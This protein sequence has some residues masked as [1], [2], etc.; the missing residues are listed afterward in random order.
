MGAVVC[1]FGRRLRL[2][3]TSSQR[4]SR[5]FVFSPPSDLKLRTQKL[6]QNLHEFSSN[7]CSTLREFRTF[8]GNFQQNARIIMSNYAGILRRSDHA[9]IFFLYQ[10]RYKSRWNDF[11]SP[12]SHKLLSLKCFQIRLWKAPSVKGAVRYGRPQLCQNKKHHFRLRSAGS[13]RIFWIKLI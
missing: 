6:P 11:S 13:K 8:I 5:L 2:Q 10:A 1:E 4:F 12:A 3:R 7:S 9:T